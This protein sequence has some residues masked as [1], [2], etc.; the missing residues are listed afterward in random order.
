MCILNYRQIPNTNTTNTNITNRSTVTN[1][2]SFESVIIRAFA[3]GA[4]V[5]AAYLDFRKAFDRVGHR[6][7]VAKLKALGVDGPLLEWIASYLK[8]RPLIVRFAGSQS[9]VFFALSGVPQGSHLGPIL[10]ILFVA[11]L[12]FADDLKLFKIIRNMHD[13]RAMQNDL[14]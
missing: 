12:L 6:H 9:Q 11:M 14:K 2:V 8:N 5:D 1:L 7:L 10:F 13:C 3:E 4:Q